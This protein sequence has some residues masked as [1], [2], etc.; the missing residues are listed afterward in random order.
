VKVKD[1]FSWSK[2]MQDEENRL[3]TVKGEEYTVSD[4]DKFKN[5]KSIG[6]RMDLQAEK[7]CLIYL[8]KHMDS[9]RNYVLTGSE[10][11]EEPIIGRIQDARNYL[12]LLGGIIEEK[13]A[14]K[15]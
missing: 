9:I 6:E 2:K 8:L 3:M 10:V 7:V 5:F 12:L 11:S 1:F 4:E 13:R 15:I 14:T